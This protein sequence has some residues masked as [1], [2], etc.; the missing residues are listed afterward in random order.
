MSSVISASTTSTTALTLSGDTS[1]Q[2]EIKTGASPTTAITIDTS[3]NVGIGTTN[4]AVRLNV[5]S[6]GNN[7]K[8]RF[9]NGTTTLDLY[10]GGTEVYVGTTNAATAWAFA[11]NNT[12]MAAYL[13]AAE[14]MRIFSSGDVAIN[15]TTAGIGKLAVNPASSTAYTTTDLAA[16]SGISVWNLTSGGF[17]NLV[18]NTVD[19]TGTKNCISAINSISETSNSLNSSMTFM[20]RQ[21][22]DQTV[23]ERMRIDS[24][25][26]VGIGLTNQTKAL[27]VYRGSADCVIRT[28]TASASGLAQVEFRNTQAGCQIG[29]P[30]NVNAMN[31]I[32]ADNERMRIDSSGA[33]Q[34]GLT[35]GNIADGRLIVAATGTGAG[36]ANTRLFMAGYELTSG[37]AAGLWFGARNNE[38]TGVIGARTAS[39]NIAFETF[40]SGWGERAR[41]TST[42][43]VLI[44]TTNAN[45]NAGNGTKIYNNGGV[46]AVGTATDSY[47]FYNSTASAYRFYVTNAGTIFATN[48]TISA[49]SDARLKENIQDIDVGLD[50]VM[51][52]K[53]RKFDWKEG[54]GKDKKGDRGWIAQ[55]FE[56]VFP[57][58]IDTWKDPAPEGEEP[59]KA[60]NADLIP[61]LVKAIQE[62]KA[63][64]DEAKAEIQA[65]KGAK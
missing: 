13:G 31:F 34:I 2:L 57:E 55:E 49:I 9:T 64:L 45:S 61:V 65:L 36:T 59:Y 21:N 25:G 28:Q 51:A 17:A 10:C 26:N 40:N 24:S 23:R 27:D 50:A 42:G 22:S 3:Q 16:V 33:L 56:Q 19:A 12:Y 32:T 14:R 41:I 6:S 15:T 43:E 54:K 11:N 62:L 39:G 4:P 37:N 46:Y 20:T 35:N 63:E 53:P 18:L 29:M 47:N 58:M 38:N 60:V 48:T 1:G 30:A 7:T 52:L 8:A 44:G 5:S